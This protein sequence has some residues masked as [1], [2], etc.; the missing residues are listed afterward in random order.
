MSSI[1]VV[2]DTNILFP[3]TLRDTLLIAA[4]VGLFQPRWSTETLAELQRNLID[5]G[6]MAAGKAGELCEAMR[7]AF[8]EAEVTGYEPYID[9]L[10]NHWKDR[11]VVAAALAASAPIIVTKDLGDFAPLP[12]E[13]IAES[14]D[15]FL[16][17]LLMTDRRKVMKA[18]HLQVSAYKKPPLTLSEVLA[19]LEADAPHFVGEARG[20]LGEGLP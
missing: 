6:V 16:R 8:E 18:L 12:V 19:T 3:R 13:V 10:R 2:L 15:E 5:D 20:L 9:G 7:E 4:E 1:A 17:R 14:P 11:H